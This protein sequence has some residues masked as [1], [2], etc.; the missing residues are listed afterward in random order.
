[1]AIYNKPFDISI[2]L[3]GFYDAFIGDH[4]RIIKWIFSLYTFSLEEKNKMFLH[5]SSL[6][7]LNIIK[8][9]HSKNIS[10]EYINGFILACS[11]GHIEMAIRAC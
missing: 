6:G 7:S 1:M 5:A 9:F 10:T 11:N 8:W 2:T 3:N 4:V